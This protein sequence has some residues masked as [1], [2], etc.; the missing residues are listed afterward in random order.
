MYT[1]KRRI[2]ININI[3]FTKLLELVT[4][5]AVKILEVIAMLTTGK[6]WHCCGVLHHKSAGD[7][8]PVNF[9]YSLFRK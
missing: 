1:I 6:P 2:H 9:F 5:K 4:R 7:S 3:Y 8:G